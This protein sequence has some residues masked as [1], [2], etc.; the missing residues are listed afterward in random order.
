MRAI[1]PPFG[2]RL[3]ALSADK[4]GIIIQDDLTVVEVSEYI[5]NAIGFKKLTPV[6]K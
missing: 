5:I 4:L 6:V 1:N 2:L 3:E